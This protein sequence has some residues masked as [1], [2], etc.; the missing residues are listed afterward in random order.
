[1]Y[2]SA[3]NSCSFVSSDSSNIIVTK[4]TCV[5]TWNTKKNIKKG[6]ID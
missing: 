1:M 6:F 5:Y 4:N 2:L 3:Y